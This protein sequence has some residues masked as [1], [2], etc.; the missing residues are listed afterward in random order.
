MPPVIDPGFSSFTV[1][2][3]GAI[4]VMISTLGVALINRIGKRKS[5]DTDQV[6]VIIGALQS[7]L[8]DA[9]EELKSLRAEFQQRN[10]YVRQLE[11]LRR[12]E[13]ESARQEAESRIPPPPKQVPPD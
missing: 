7:D 4:T 3:V 5:E 1:G 8:K 6:A 9:R 10:Q 2:I 11:E 12:H 13:F